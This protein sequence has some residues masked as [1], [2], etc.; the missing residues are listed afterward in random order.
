MLQRREIMMMPNCTVFRQAYA[1]RI[2]ADEAITARTS[3]SILAE[4]SRCGTARVSSREGAASV[5]SMSAIASSMSR[6]RRL[7]SSSR[8]RFK[9]LRTLEGIGGAVPANA[10]DPS[11]MIDPSER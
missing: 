2:V 6:R 7:E 4:T 10:G 5:S 3:S 9:S 1:T 11:G 8:Q